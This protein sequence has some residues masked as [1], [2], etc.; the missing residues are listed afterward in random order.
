MRKKKQVTVCFR[1]SISK[2]EENPIH[3]K[4]TKV[5]TDK[6]PAV[7]YGLMMKWHK[8][9]KKHKIDPRQSFDMSVHSFYLLIPPN[10]LLCYCFLGSSLKA[11]IFKK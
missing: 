1:F 10:V 5:L 2:K 8:K 4:K 6:D 3:I 9:R 7:I 11:E